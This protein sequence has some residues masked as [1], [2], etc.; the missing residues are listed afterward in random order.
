MKL[1]VFLFDVSHQSVLVL[2]Y[3]IHD[4]FLELGTVCAAVEDSLL[5]PE[6]L[7]LLLLLLHGLDHLLK[8]LEVVFSV[9]AEEGAV[10]TYLYTVSETDYLLL[11]FVSLAKTTLKS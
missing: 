3:L 11:L 8:G 10:R 6:G 9:G 4:V 2:P 7:E 5:R 1:R